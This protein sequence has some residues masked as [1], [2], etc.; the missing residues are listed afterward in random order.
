VPV[1]IILYFTLREDL[2]DFPIPTDNLIVEV[3]WLFSLDCFFDAGCDKITIVL[4]HHTQ[5]LFE[6]R[7]AVGGLET[8]NPKYFIRPFQFIT[9]DSPGPIPHMSHPLGVDEPQFAFPEI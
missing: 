7:R 5:K 2:S 6:I 1:G 8:E 9:A 4:V 3:V